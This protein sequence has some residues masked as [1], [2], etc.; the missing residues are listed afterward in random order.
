MGIRQRTKERYILGQIAATLAC[1]G[2]VLYLTSSVHSVPSAA[3]FMQ[4]LAEIA[5]ANYYPYHS[6]IGEAVRVETY[7]RLSSSTALPLSW[8]HVQLYMSRFLT[9]LW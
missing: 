5:G 4:R 3:G 9:C 1:G 2:Q 8:G 7:L 6:L